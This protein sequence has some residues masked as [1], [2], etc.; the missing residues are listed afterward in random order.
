[1]LEYFSITKLE[2]NPDR[3]INTI[4]SDW[5]IK[6]PQRE[7]IESMV[8]EF[9]GVGKIT[10]LNIAL[11]WF[12]T[13]KRMIG[14]KGSLLEHNDFQLEYMRPEHPGFIQNVGYAVIPHNTKISN[15]I[16]QIHQIHNK[17]YE[18]D[19]KFLSMYKPNIVDKAI[20]ESVNT[21]LNKV[22]NINI[23]ENKVLYETY[24]QLL[25]DL[26]L[27]LLITT[28][29]CNG[30]GPYGMRE[31]FK[32]F[33][34]SKYDN[35]KKI[36]NSVNP[37]AKPAVEPKAQAK[38]ESEASAKP[39]V[40]PEAQ[41]K[42]GPE[43]SAKPEVKP[44]VKH[45]VK[46]TMDLNKILVPILD[47][48][49]YYM[50]YGDIPEGLMLGLNLKVKL[51]LWKM[52]G[53]MSKSPK[54]LFDPNI[55]DIW[56]KSI[57]SLVTCGNHLNRVYNYISDIFPNN[58]EESEESKDQ[59][60]EKSKDEVAVISDEQIVRRKITHSLT[61]LGIYGEI[62][63][64]Y[65][66]ADKTSPIDKFINE[67][68][69]ISKYAV[70]IEIIKNADII[71]DYDGTIDKEE[72]L[73]IVN[74]LANNL[75]IC[76]LTG[77]D[78]AS[79]ISDCQQ[80]N[81]PL[82]KNITIL[83]VSDIFNDTYIFPT[84]L[85]KSMYLQTTVAIIK[86]CLVKESTNTLLDDSKLVKS[87]FDFLQLTKQHFINADNLEYGE[88][89]CNVAIAYLNKIFYVKPKVQLD[90]K[91]A[92]K[93]KAQSKVQLGNKAAVKSK[94]QPEVQPEVQ[95]EVQSEVQP[96][97][98]SEVQSEVQPEVQPG[99]QP[100]VQPEV[101]PGVQPE[102]QPG[103]Q[104]EVQLEVQPVVQPEVE[105]KINHILTLLTNVTNKW[106]EY[107]LTK[108]I[109]VDL[110]IGKFKVYC[111]KL[112]ELLTKQT[113]N[114]KV[115][116]FHGHAGSGKSTFINALYSS[117]KEK[118]Y[119]FAKDIVHLVGNDSKLVYKFNGKKAG[120]ANDLALYLIKLT[121]LKL[122]DHTSYS[123]ILDGATF[124][125]GTFYS[126]QEIEKFMEDN[127]IKLEGRKYP[128]LEYVDL[129]CKGRRDVESVFENVPIIEYNEKPLFEYLEL[130]KPDGTLGQLSD[131]IK[132]NKQ[133]IIWSAFNINK[134]AFDSVQLNTKDEKI[135][136]D[137]KK[138]IKDKEELHA[139]THF[140]SPNCYILIGLFLL[141]Q[142]SDCTIYITKLVHIFKGGNL[143]AVLLI[144]EIMKKDGTKDFQDKSLNSPNHITLYNILPEGPGIF[145][146]IPYTDKQF[147]HTEYK[148]GTP[149]QFKPEIAFQIVRAKIN[150][151][152]DSK[153]EKKSAIK[154][155][156]S[157]KDKSTSAKKKQKVISGP[158]VKPEVK[159]H[160]CASASCE[161]CAKRKK[162]IKYKLK[163]IT[164]KKNLLY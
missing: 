106:Y 82:H 42:P 23:N 48:L 108:G 136:A 72:K 162:Y 37:D 131:Y 163:Y 112:D 143:V 59:Y 65:N 83:S 44:E 115:V 107:D 104:P 148:F 39:A 47:I 98:Q 90:D 11:Y 127:S 134:L 113:T 36:F 26:I 69:K 156:E 88:F 160:E 103:V 60:V 63:K 13:N 8:T 51:Q 9:S 70:I 101:Q 3:D 149:I 111:D 14:T 139:Y 145:H 28:S 76:I 79:L 58:L 126:A 117:S 40:K 102:V 154:P 137:M 153:S 68:Q 135:L 114:Y 164:L 64:T 2:Y 50:G 49:L 93:L 151:I 85:F 74:E 152:P 120:L 146:T 75:T 87:M 141:N 15:S 116:P 128:I 130:N 32:R 34:E 24:T 18:A 158:E 6:Q 144:A 110:S 43:A 7:S 97:V 81:Q 73:R 16:L 118:P 100:E 99:V 155:E 96:E 62:I 125:K 57:P 52:A 45:G 89:V 161:E 46:T 27:I 122:S 12:L 140:G 38:P 4:I 33:E 10:G 54:A 21:F 22:L 55:Q 5:L 80:K 29:S 78:K 71:F 84:A 132:M 95:S 56:A 67:L 109:A 31:I 25:K 124:T 119:L 20:P 1:M 94:V 92:F 53:G 19:I 30:I 150:Q 61:N 86:A 157:S 142:F 41:A 147:K 159:P 77:R 123:I 35:L 129:L 91:A 138:L 17:I 121:T 105:V 133:S 66:N